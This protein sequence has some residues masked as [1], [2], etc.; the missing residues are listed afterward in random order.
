MIRHIVFWKLRDDLSG[1][2]RDDAV[3][4]I[5]EG[6][7]AIRGQLPGLRQIEVGVAISEGDESAD[8]ILYSEFDSRAALAGYLA[9]PLH[10]A[11]VPVV[12]QART[13]RRVGDYET[14]PA[15]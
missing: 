12:R 15:G 4:Q 9:H 2:A 3:R 14:S 8:L 13:E 11:M 10:E 6:L 5:K 1:P 7:E